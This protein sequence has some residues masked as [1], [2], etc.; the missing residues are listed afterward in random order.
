MPK[1]PPNQ[2]QIDAAKAAIDAITANIDAVIQGKHEVVRTVVLAFMARGHVLLEDY[3]GTGKTTLVSTLAK[4]VDCGFSRI[5]F[6]PDVMP[7]DVSG[8]SIY[9]QK[10]QA[11]EFRPG[12]VMSNLVLADEINRASPKTQSAM[13]EAMEERQVTVERNTYPLEEP[14]M[15]L[16]TQN[17]IE[18]G[19]TFKLPEAQLDRF[20]VKLSMGY[21]DFGAEVQMLKHAREAKLAVR[22]VLSGDDVNAV[23]AVVDTVYVSDAVYRY[24]VQIMNATRG[25]AELVLGSSPRG[26]IA[27]CDLARALAASE[28][29][30]YVL[31]DDVKALAHAVLRHRVMPKRQ[32]AKEGRSPDDIITSV[33]GGIDVPKADDAVPEAGA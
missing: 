32:A 8:F 11:F 13:L 12:G 25:S 10:T 9:N 29:R 19:G 16:A 21:P 18:Q 4:S 7:S 31:P 33:L 3:P 6:T 30:A 20:M 2:S 23:R 5:Q 14:F 24:V 15:V 22:P 27:L 1:Q 17:P 26:G 28:G